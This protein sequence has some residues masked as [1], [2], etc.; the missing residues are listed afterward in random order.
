MTDYIIFIFL[1]YL[2]PL[3]EG[4]RSVPGLQDNNYAVKKNHAFVTE[5][6]EKN[7]IFSIHLLQS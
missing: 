2:L 1:L 3:P 7:F 5:M 4:S 6:K